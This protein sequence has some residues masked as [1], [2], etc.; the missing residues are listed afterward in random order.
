MKVTGAA[1]VV[2]LAGLLAVPASADHSSTPLIRLSGEGRVRTAVAVSRFSHPD[3]ARVAFVANASGPADALAAVP[4]A[5]AWRAP[6]LLSGRDRLDATTADEL[7][8]LDAQEVVLVGGTAAL[9]PAVAAEVAASGY[10]VRR[11]AGP[12]R[13]ATAAELARLLDEEHAGPPAE[14]FVTG[15]DPVD[16]RGWPDAIAAGPLAARSG[17]PVLLT[18][19]TALPE[20]TRA[21]LRDAGGAPVI[22]LGGAGAVSEEVV[23][24][25]EREG[26]SVRRLAGPDRYA[27]ALAASREAM[28]RRQAAGE[29]RPEVWVATG[30]GFPDALSAGPAAA[31]GLLV[32]LRGTDLLHTFRTTQLLIALAEGT[33]R[34][35]VVGGEQAIGGL[36]TEELARLPQAGAPA[37]ECTPLLDS[38]RVRRADVVVEAVFREG[39]TTD[40]G[41]EDA[42]LSP[43]T[44]DVTKVDK[45]APALVIEVRTAV[46]QRGDQTGMSSV[47]ILPRAG[48]RWRL[49]LHGTGEEPYNTSVC[50]GSAQAG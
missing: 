38:M 9:G 50:D 11:V 28:G 24:A 14:V 31:D 35:V 29:P 26:H 32:L 37:P 13:F 21:A 42:L 7:D 36:V 45:G 46:F 41:R 33:P 8:R 22:V 48:E 5:Y 1:A 12:D 40:A 10:D 20:P 4:L 2:V 27:T 47:G 16:D 17:A 25:I 18:A 23:Q 6:V 19:P 15:S 39:P 43:A 3:G 44:A 49:R 30:E 34:Y